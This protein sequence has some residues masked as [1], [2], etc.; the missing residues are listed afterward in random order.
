MLQIKPIT[1]PIFFRPNIFKAIETYGKLL[2]RTNRLKGFKY[3]C[4][5]CLKNRIEDKIRDKIIMASIYYWTGGK[6]KFH[7]GVSIYKID[8]LI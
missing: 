8:L 6:I 7:H 1:N 3:G 5:E 2:S 4:K